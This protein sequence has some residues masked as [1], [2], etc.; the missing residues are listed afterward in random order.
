[1]HREFHETLISACPSR[2]LLQF[3]RLLFAQFRRYRRLVLKRCWS[4]QALRATVDAEHKRVMDAALGRQADKAAE[5][6]AQH[7]SRSVERVIAEYRKA[8]A[9]N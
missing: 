9:G 8:D 1:M 7:Y 6:L 3:C 4:S 5:L 2:R